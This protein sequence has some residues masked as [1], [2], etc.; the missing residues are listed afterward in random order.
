MA[1]YYAEQ[2]L[3]NTSYINTSIFDT[4]FGYFSIYI[5][6]HKYMYLWEYLPWDE[7]NIVS[8]LKREYGWE[9]EE[10][11]KQT[12]RIDDGSSA[13]YNYIYYCVQGFTE[14]DTFRSN[15]IRENQMSRKEALRLVHEENKPRYE[16][17]KW[18]FDS[19]G[20]DG[21][22]VLTAVDKIPRLY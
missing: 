13:F 20:L 2:F 17:L 19:V 7:D 16:A 21:D 3:K 1:L 18:Y 22:M 11:K 5:K 12:W 6:R 15:Q 14:N 4:A 8:T 9:A 10:E